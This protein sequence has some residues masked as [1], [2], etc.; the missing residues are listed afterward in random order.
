MN[1]M[2]DRVI[3]NDVSWGT[4]AGGEAVC[5]VHSTLFA[6]A[7]GLKKYIF[8]YEIKTGKSEL[9]NGTGG[10]GGLRKVRVPWEDRPRG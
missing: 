2:S 3:G 1:G 4:V 6:T 9:V 10:G 7:L 8:I 5:L